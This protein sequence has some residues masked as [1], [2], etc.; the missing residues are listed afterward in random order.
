[1]TNKQQGDWAEEVVCNAI[2]EY[3]PDF[4]AV[5][6]GR[7]DSLDAGDP[8]FAEFY[9][10]YQVEL[11]TIGKKPDILIF[12]HADIADNTSVPDLD[13]DKFVQSAIAAI[14]VR[15]SSFL[16]TRYASFMDNRTRTA[17]SECMRLRETILSE[18][19]GG[20]LE[21]RRPP[22]YKMISDATI[23]TFRELT[24]VARGW[25]SSPV[26]AELSGYLKELKEQIKILQTRDYL[27]IT[28]KIE[29]IVSVNRWIQNYG[30]PHHYLQVFFDKAYIISFADILEITSDPNT[31]PV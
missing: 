24:F 11:N 21:Q 27:S 13:D 19:Y 7:S 18:P 4:Y 23:D 10:E 31:N 8:G 26:L 29:D 12:Q 3:S 25:Y 16:A 17:E 20:I 5:R 15:S 22:L 9:S 30:I 14:E 1:M 6:Y 28:P 2:N